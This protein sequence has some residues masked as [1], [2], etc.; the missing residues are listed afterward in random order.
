MP[1]SGLAVAR[2]LA[3]FAFLIPRLI[4]PGLARVLIDKRDSGIGIVINGPITRETDFEFVRAIADIQ[5]S[6]LVGVAF[7]LN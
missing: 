2:Y 3:I 6:D 4:S 1:L 7:V 5:V